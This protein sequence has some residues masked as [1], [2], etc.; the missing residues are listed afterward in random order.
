MQKDAKKPNPIDLDEVE[1][2]A[3]SSF[4][5]NQALKI[6]SD[7]SLSTGRKWQAILSEIFKVTGAE[8]TEHAPIMTRQDFE[9]WAAGRSKLGDGKFIWVFK[10]LTHPD[11]LAR[12]E[13]SKAKD[14][15][16][17][18]AIERVGNTFA[19]YFS[20][21]QMSGYIRRVPATETIDDETIELRM[22]GFQGCFVG[23]DNTQE[24]CLSLERYGQSHFFVSHFFCW[25]SNP[26]GVPS[27]WE[28]ERFSGFCTVG[29]MMRLHT[30]GIV[31]QTVRDMFLLPFVDHDEDQVTGYS[32]IRHSLLTKS[33]E[34]IQFDNFT[35]AHRRF[36]FIDPTNH[37]ITLER[38]ADSQL[39][40]FIDQ[41]RWNMVP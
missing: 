2:R 31:V 39:S 6:L 11:T 35:A 26:L 16:G 40:E 9:S 37:T 13:F 15:V 18:G 20:D 10:F 21:Y 34:S 27:D 22:N 32:L 17:F 14:L 4:E 29:N 8:P 3:F 36:K 28:S 33:I 1:G 24:C 25:P 7:Y 12:A 30:K 19:D 23:K 41:F 38:S 5:K